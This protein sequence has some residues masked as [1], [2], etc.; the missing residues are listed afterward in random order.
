[1]RFRD[2]IAEDVDFYQLSQVE[3]FVEALWDKLGVEV[4]FT[5]HFLDRLNDSRNGKPISSAE[6]I[7]LFKKEY[8][9]N[10]K[11]ISKLGD[12]EAVMKD[13]LTNINLPFVIK[14]TGH[15]KEMVA[16]TIMRKPNFKTPDPEFVVSESETF[17]PPALSTGD[18]VLVGKFK[19]RKA[20]IKGFKKDEN[21]QPVLKTTK[22]DQKLFKP[23]ISKLLPKS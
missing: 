5:K 7:R 10:G 22:G 14:D 11:D 4:K 13:L 9:Q 20:E 17:H 15:G 21:N 16:K 2:I 1:M 18:T 3:H 8:E 12:T 23:R 6:L 19:N